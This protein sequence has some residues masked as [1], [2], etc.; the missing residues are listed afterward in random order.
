M[1]ILVKVSGDLAESNE[2]YDWLAS[3][4]S[5]ENKLFVL[6]G[7][8]T[9]ITKE[10][11]YQKIPFEFGPAG[12]EISSVRGK[13]LAKYILEKQ[14]YIIETRSKWRGLVIS[15]LM[16]FIHVGDKLCHLNADDYALAL[17]PNFDKIYI[18]TVRGRAKTF[19]EKFKKIEVVCL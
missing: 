18:V 5:F 8:G 15:V 10:L 14:K 6:C 16:P 13:V 1:D 19:P 2:F 11:N 4:D 7:G 9:L 12:R 17:Y 3:I